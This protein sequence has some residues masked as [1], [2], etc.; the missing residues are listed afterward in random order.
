ME[1]RDF[2]LEAGEKAGLS[3]SEKQLNQLV[4]Y[5]ELLVEWNQKMNL[6]AITEPQEV[7]VKH[8]IDSLSCYDETLFPQ[9]ASVIDVG[10]GAGFPGMVL[11][12]YRPDLQLTLL[13]SL[14]KR[15]TFLKTLQTE[16]DLG[17]IEFIH[18]RAEDAGRDKKLRDRFAVVVSRAVARLNV[19][20]E[21]CLPFA[22][23]GGFFLALKGRDAKAE[24][25]EAS[26]AL[27]LLGGKI[28]TVKQVFLPELTDERFVVIVKKTAKTPQAYPR[29]PVSIE[30][31]PL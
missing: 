8:M 20:T 1:F 10:T 7:A 9:G 14:N 12:I 16:L 15:L 31:K 4:R 26:R 28:E 27:T 3:F 6:T 5:Y 23:P 21:Y 2:L 13:D 19:L 24:A 18:G 25:K 29:R 22:A 17:P 11:K 30:K